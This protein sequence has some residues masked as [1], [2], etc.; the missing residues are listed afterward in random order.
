[1]RAWLKATRTQHACTRT[2]TRTRARTWRAWLK[3][4]GFP[5]IEGIGR[6][7]AARVSAD[8]ARAGG[9]SLESVMGPDEYNYPVNNS[10]YT[11][12]VASLALAAAVELAPLVC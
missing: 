4:I 9:F 6:F 1:M 10:R 8:P 2:H 11:N 5:L 3:A 12:T 7:Y